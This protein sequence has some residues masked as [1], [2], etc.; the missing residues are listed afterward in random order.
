[1]GQCACKW[2]KNVEEAEIVIREQSEK[3][4]VRM[5][6]QKSKTFKWSFTQKKWT[7]RHSLKHT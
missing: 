7:L 2:E 5:Y 4:N 6:R 3:L 1:M